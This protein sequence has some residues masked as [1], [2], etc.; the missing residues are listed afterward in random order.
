LRIAAENAL[1]TVSFP[2][3][4][5]G[6]GGFPIAQAADLILGVIVEFIKTSE[7]PRQVRVV[8]LDEMTYEIFSTRWQALA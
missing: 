8:L 7:Y 2:A 3:I 5:T 1:D 6:V 4:G